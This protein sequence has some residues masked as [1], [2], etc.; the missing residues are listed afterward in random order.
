M[1]RQNRYGS[2]NRK[3]AAAHASWFG[4][5]LG[6][7]RMGQPKVSAWAGIALRRIENQPEVLI[8]PQ[9]RAIAL[10]FTSRAM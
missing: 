5:G 1:K 3:R 9:K 2:Q 10:R 6:H 8:V 7:G 4:K